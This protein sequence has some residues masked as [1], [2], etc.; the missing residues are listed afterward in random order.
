MTTLETMSPVEVDDAELVARSLRGSRDAFGQIVARHQALVCSLA[1][2]ATGRL[3]ES[4]DLAQETF[5]TAWKQLS[6]L[7]EPAK[8]RSWLCGI[9]KNL[10]HRTRRGQ[11][12]EPV[13]GAEPLEAVAESAARDPQ[14]QEQAISREEEG[15]L[16]RS[17]ERIPETYREPLILFYRE[18]ESVERVA[19][20]LELSEDAV[21]QRLVRG[22]KL[23]HEQ[24]LAFVEGTLEKTSPGRKFTIGVLAALPMTATTTKAAAVGA[25]MA[26]GGAAIKSAATVGSLGGWLAMLGSSYVTLRAQADDTKSA[27]ER[28]FV[29]QMIWVRITAFLLIGAGFYGF[30]ELDLSRMAFARAIFAAAFIFLLYAIAMGVFVYGSRRQ[31]RIQIEEKTY[32]E[33]EWTL[34]RRKTDDAMNSAGI[35]FDN[36]KVLKFKAVGLALLA[37]MIYQAPWKE[38]LGEAIFW[39]VACGL[40]LVLSFLT[41]YSRPRY[42]SLRQS[43]VVWVP[44]LMGLMTLFYFNLHQYQARAGADISSAASP[45]EVF[46]FNLAIGLA[47]AVLVGIM[48]GTRRNELHSSR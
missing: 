23:L 31:R 5:V 16:W 29:L 32:N 4:E 19:L 41:W 10:G 2:S 38:H 30:G 40:G 12:H 45:A 17:L 8:L 35:G 28:Q 21:R 39:S 18:Q 25:S 3:A 27:R 1:Y 46:G 33:A 26:T 7:R 34:P 15:I 6:G 14:P 43:W 47:Y 13:Y 42:L 9:V 20:A 11:E 22:R 44:V 37:V 24:V 36:F 48:I